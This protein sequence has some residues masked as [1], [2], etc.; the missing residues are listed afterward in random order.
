MFPGFQRA[1]GAVVCALLAH[2]CTCRSNPAFGQ[3]W[4]QSGPSGDLV[5]LA[6]VD[7]L[8]VLSSAVHG[9]S[10]DA[11]VRLMRLARAR[12]TARAG[13]SPAGKTPVTEQDWSQV[14]IS[15]TAVRNVEPRSALQ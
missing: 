9:A 3:A 2:W 14:L 8:A 7:E 1:A 4:A 13:G 12:I 10:R 6:A 5:C 15:T 11:A